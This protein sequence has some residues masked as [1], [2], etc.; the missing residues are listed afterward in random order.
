MRLGQAVK[1]KEMGNFLSA[2]T[3][4]KR[5][6]EYYGTSKGLQEVWNTFYLVSFVH[7]EI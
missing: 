3:L 7:S 1:Y 2:K 4:S 6:V 5:V